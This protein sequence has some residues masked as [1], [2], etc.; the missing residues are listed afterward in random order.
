[1]TPRPMPERLSELAAERALFGL[2]AAEALE[3]ERLEAEHGASE[4]SELELAAAELDLALA[5][6]PLEPLPESVLAALARAGEQWNATRVHASAPAP[7]G[8]R[9][10]VPPA[11]T[12][13]ASV[14]P[15]AGWVLA[16]AAAIAAVF[17]WLREPH[18]PGARDPEQTYV[19]LRSVP[20]T[21]NPSFQA[22]ANA[23][24]ATGDVAWSQSGQQGVLHLVGL[25]AND[26]KV[27]QYQLWIIDAEQKQPIDGGVFDAAGGEG[28]IAIDPKLAVAHPTAFA[29]TLEK[30]GG[31]VVSAQDRVV[32]VATL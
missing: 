31:V 9:R 10:A 22:T 24:G 16:A 27:E 3:L 23:P 5:K 11:A 1:M 30:P 17:G 21:V 14:L 13:P 15:L 19:A 2:A 25:P 26:P 29:V 28:W 32:L 12:R 18:F 20:G 4:A 7:E 8:P 6:Q